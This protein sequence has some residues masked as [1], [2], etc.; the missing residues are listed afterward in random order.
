MDA[1]R[2]L[3]S[4]QTSVRIEPAVGLHSFEVRGR[5]E[6]RASVLRVL[7]Q[8]PDGQLETIPARNLYHG[9]VRPLGLTGRF[10]ESGIKGEAFDASRITPAMDA[11]WYDPVVPEPYLAVWDGTLDVPNGGEYRFEVQGVGTVKLFID[12][13]LLAQHP[14]AESAPAEASLRLYAG[15][16][17]IRVEYSSPS[18]PSQ[19]EVLWA[20]P[21][22]P[23]EP[24]P[25]EQLSP[26]PEQMFTVVGNE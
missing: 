13:D 11:F 2:I 15:K 6:D 24:L 22:R 14:P 23:L 3:W 18:P 10:Y 4:D 8:P 26:A 12:G 21:D 20:P 16:H 9:S 19:F 7:W 1:R 5:V 25:I 17:R